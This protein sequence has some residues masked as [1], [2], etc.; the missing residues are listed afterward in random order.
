MTM[1]IH[2]EKSAN[3]LLRGISTS[4]KSIAGL[5]DVA[6]GQIDLKRTIAFEFDARGDDIFVVTYPRSGTT[7]MQ[8]MLYQLTTD[9][10]MDFQHINGVAPWFERRI[11]SNPEAAMRY[12]ATLP[13]PR[14]FKS[15]L[16]HSDT[17]KSRGRYIYVMR[18][19]QDVLVSYYHF[20]RSHL[21]FQGSFDEFF[22]AFMKGQVQ[23]QSW[24]QHVR[25]WWQHRHDPRV[26][27]LRY[28]EVIADLA[29]SIRTVAGFCDI[30][31]DP[32]RFPVILERCG[33]PFMKRHEEKF[34]H[35]TGLA[36]D[37]GYQLNA[38]I[39]QGKKGQGEGFLT[40]PQLER[41]TRKVQEELG[42]IVAKT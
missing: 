21:S 8:M 7:L 1:K 9:G 20:Y 33:F 31:I 26:L 2:A 28:E 42:E 18:D 4:L 38:F 3:A 19:G 14:V 10:N 39:R 37:R 25:G 15:H 36:L 35:T 17:P 41:L 12:F 40:R 6:A 27:F 23:F 13:S 32:E 5:I 34:D 30:D 29:G 22:E 16:P 11:L 24:F